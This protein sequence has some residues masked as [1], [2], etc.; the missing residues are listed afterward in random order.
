[1]PT[2]CQNCNKEKGP[3]HVC[4]QPEPANAVNGPP[5]LHHPEL[6]RQNGNYPHAPPHA[7][8]PPP[9]LGRVDAV[10]GHLPVGQPHDLPPGGFN[11]QNQNKFRRNRSTKKSLRKSK[12][13]KSKPKKSKS[14]K[15]NRR[16]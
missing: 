7:P 1:M 11:Y 6:Q 13:K 4:P 16:V 14:R 8:P 2:K 12:S 10:G 3:G 9:Q 5:P 15:Y